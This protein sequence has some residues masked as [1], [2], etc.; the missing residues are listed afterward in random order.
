MLVLSSSIFCTLEMW[1]YLSQLWNFPRVFKINWSG[2][3]RSLICTVIVSAYQGYD[4]PSVVTTVSQSWNISTP[5]EIPCLR[6]SMWYCGLRSYLST[7][8]LHRILEVVG[9]ICELCKINMFFLYYTYP[10][11]IWQLHASLVHMTISIQFYLQS[12]I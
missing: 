5:F 4:D 8:S 2:S 3:L 7:Q 10:Y 12:P 11:N 1:S 9:R 6:G